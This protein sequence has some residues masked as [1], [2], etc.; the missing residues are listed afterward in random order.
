MLTRPRPSIDAILRSAARAGAA[1][2]AGIGALALVGWALDVEALRDGA[3]GPAGITPGAALSFVLIG[4]SLFLLCAPSGGRGVAVGARAAALLVT[5]SSLVAGTHELHGQDVALDSLLFGVPS[6]AVDGSDAGGTG[7]SSAL[8]FAL[9]G[10]ALLSLDVRRRRFDPA[11]ALAFV[12]SLLALLALIGAAGGVADGDLSDGLD[13]TVPAA[14]AFLAVS[15]GTA[16]ARPERPWVRLLVGDTPG[17]KLLR[18]L[19]P[20]CVAVPLGLSALR[21]AGEKAGVYDGVI[22][23][24]LLATAATAVL[25]P[26]VWKLGRSLDDADAEQRRAEEERKELEGRLRQSERLESVG[27]LAGGVA[28]DFNNLLA[29]ILNYSAFLAERVKGDPDANHDAEEIRRA[30]ERAGALTR[31]LLVFSRQE[32]VDPQ[33]LHLNAVVA[34]TETL[35]RR[36]L[37]EHVRLET[38]LDPDLRRI[39]ADPSQLEQVLVNLAVNARDAMPTG[40]ALTIE[41][42]NVEIDEDYARAR[43]GMPTGRA[44]RLTVSDT[45]RGMPSDVA[46]HAFEPFFTTKGK[47]QGTGLG[48]ATVYG[49]VTQAGGHVD[50]CTEPGIGTSFHVYM[51]VTEEAAAFRPASRESLL[52][53]SGETVLVVEDESAVRELAARILFGHGYAVMQAG[54]AEEAVALAN[55][56]ADPP[57]VLL[58]DVVMPGVSG[59]ALAER[60]RAEH[61]RLAVLYMSGYTADFVARQDLVGEDVALIE[62]PFDAQAL[63]R[64]VQDVLYGARHL[65]S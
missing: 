53:A 29:V 16:L 3:A 4:A 33:V 32:V 38:R 52:R 39:K 34:E 49:I 51:P 6:D 2:A 17:G 43:A 24:W 11:P 22:G 28:H 31:Q 9:G 59:P 44:V 30:A 64:S 7:S 54:D 61:P 18:R 63:L 5:V 47:G 60:L 55:G 56:D 25:L 1:V 12:V 41:T 40:G 15:I 14:V 48:L 62:K 42:A 36:T 35:L 8:T 21:R 58:T 45:G 50:L 19:V 20:A 65:V 13:I 37:G 46:D 10:L 26:F 27:Q 23:D 57:D